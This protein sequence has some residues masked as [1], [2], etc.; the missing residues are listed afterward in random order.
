MVIT[1]LIVVAIITGGCSV[2]GQVII[3]KSS[4]KTHAAVTDVK[5][6]GIKKEME[7]LSVDVKK[8]NCFMERIAVLENKDLNM[9]TLLTEIKE[10]CKDNRKS[11]ITKNQEE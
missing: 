11:C 9:I 5:L 1:E 3:S 7:K 2:V 6:E 4:A 8:H 10:T